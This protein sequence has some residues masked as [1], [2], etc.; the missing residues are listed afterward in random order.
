M[1]GGNESTDHYLVR[2]PLQGAQRKRPCSVWKTIGQLIDESLDFY[3][4]KSQEEAHRSTWCAVPGRVAALHRGAG[5]R[6]S[7]RARQSG[8]AQALIRQ[9]V[10]VDTN[11]LVAGLLNETARRPLR[12]YSTACSQPDFTSSCPRLCLPNTEPCSCGRH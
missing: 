6:G 12:R 4:I 9:P 10:I 8:A 1:W 7:P 5:A 11:V 3:G 2:G